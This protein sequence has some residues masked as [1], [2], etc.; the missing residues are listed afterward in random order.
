MALRLIIKNTS[1]KAG[2]ASKVITLNPG[3]HYTLQSGDI[4]RALDR[5]DIKIFRRKQSLVIR[6]TE[7]EEY[8]LDNFYDGTSKSDTRQIF[9]WDD[10][11]GESKATAS[12]AV[13]PSATS[14]SVA[15]APG[16]TSSTDMASS[17]A[18]DTS[19]SSSSDSASSTSTSSNT[20]SSAST[21]AAAGMMGSLFGGNPVAPFALAGGAVAAVGLAASGGGGGGGVASTVISGL[22]QGGPVIAGL[23]GTCQALTVVA[24]DKTGKLIVDAE[25]KEISAKVD[26]TGRYS[27]DLGSYTGAVTLVLRDGNG[28]APDYYDEA[29]GTKSVGTNFSA[30]AVAGGGAQTININALT[31][32]AATAIGSGFND[33]TVV[34]N[35]NSK[36]AQ[37]FLNMSGSD[38]TALN[39]NATINVDAS[40]ARTVNPNANTVG[41]VLALLSAAEQLPS[42]YLTSAETALK[43][44]LAAPTDATK[45]TDLVN[46]LQSLYVQA[47]ARAS[48]LGVG[49]SGMT[50]SNVDTVLHT[51]FP[52]VKLL[53]VGNSDVI[54]KNGGVLGTATVHFKF[55]QAPDAGTFTVADLVVTGANAAGAAVVNAGTLSNLTASAS[56]PTLYTA[57]F[58]PTSGTTATTA[59]IALAAGAA[60]TVSGVTYTQG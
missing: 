35:V 48:G 11:S 3:Q 52:D 21:G 22:F 36:V 24:Y 19:S 44:A 50:T 15:V 45:V 13:Q 57:T 4:A 37:Y 27:L 38:V 58:T 34:N 59:N 2:S 41:Q 43:A 31:T 47:G 40:A 5:A 29:G 55:A 8:V 10:S 25:G 14:E 26:A 33:A 23:A 28:A 9:S 18:G 60:I 54:A 53:I 32:I 7:G 56:D 30:V 17:G 20:S 49:V 1:V 51:V 6:P 12:A 16:A 39:P 46:K 42:A